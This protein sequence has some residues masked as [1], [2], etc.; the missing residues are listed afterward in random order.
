[1][2][3]PMNAPIQVGSDRFRAILRDQAEV[4]RQVERR[5][6]LSALVVILSVPLWVAAAWPRFFPDG[7]RRFLLYIFGVL[8]VFVAVSVVREWRAARRLHSHLVAGAA[9]ADD[10][11]P[12]D[13]QQ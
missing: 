5:R 10:D 2:T 4:E 13:E 9:L 8:L 1:M 7:D 6:F 12:G 3:R 11:D